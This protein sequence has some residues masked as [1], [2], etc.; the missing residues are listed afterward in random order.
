MNYLIISILKIIQLFVQCE[1]HHSV[2]FS[3][4]SILLAVFSVE[5][6]VALILQLQQESAPENR[7]PWYHVTIVVI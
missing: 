5:A 2:R 4:P 1:R 3:A 6:T 7:K